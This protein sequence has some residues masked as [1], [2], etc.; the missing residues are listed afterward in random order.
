M[1]RIVV[2]EA[3]HHEITVMAHRALAS[4][5]EHVPEGAG[6]KNY[7]VKKKEGRCAGAKDE[8]RVAPTA[9]RIFLFVAQQGVE[10]K[11]QAQIV[12]KIL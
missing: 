8:K 11:V 1:S 6:L 2:I 9:R 3:P 12:R 7:G 10:K 5:V 4:V